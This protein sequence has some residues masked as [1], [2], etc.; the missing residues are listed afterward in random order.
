MLILAYFSKKYN[1]YKERLEDGLNH[2]FVGL[3]RSEADTL[4]SL[5]AE[6][7]A[8]KQDAHTS[9]SLTVEH[10]SIKQEADT[11]G[12]SINRSAYLDQVI[13]LQ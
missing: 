2:A 3:Y 6:R 8:I 4:D 1:C 7:G 5:T 13:E 9:S 11:L 10:N 12:S